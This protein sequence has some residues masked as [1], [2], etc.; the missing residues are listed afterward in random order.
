MKLRASLLA[1]AVPSVLLLA[2]CASAPTGPSV[3][4]LPGG[5]KSFDQ[6]RADDMDCR[7]YAQYQ[8]GGSSANQSSIESG[9]GS[10]AIGTAVGAAAGALIGGHSGAG[11]GAGAG[12]LVGSAAGTGAA[13]TSAN[14]TQR[15]YDNAYVQ[16][17][18]AKGNQVPV[19]TSQV[20]SRHMAPP[21]SSGGYYPPPPPGSPPPPPPSAPGY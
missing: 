6:F 1:V 15:N 9:V 11:V 17:M 5:G 18:Y 3:M 14:A 7:Q 20:R 8:I 21:P 19:A 10:A 12:L 2:G 16:C 13:Q 4:A